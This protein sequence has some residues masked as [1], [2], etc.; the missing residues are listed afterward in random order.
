MHYN[1]EVHLLV[2]C[3]FWIDVDCERRPE[4]VNI[5]CVQNAV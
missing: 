4:H 5:L 2:I 3:I 1:I